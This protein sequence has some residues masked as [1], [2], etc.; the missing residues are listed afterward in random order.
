LKEALHERK[1]IMK[2]DGIL[3]DSI[4]LELSD[5]ENESVQSEDKEK[6]QEEIRR[7]EQ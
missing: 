4:E 6:N 3:D 1:K 7:L 2:E 5:E